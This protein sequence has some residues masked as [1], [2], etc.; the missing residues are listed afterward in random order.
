MAQGERA[1]GQRAESTAP[2]QDRPQ[3]AQPSSFSGFGSEQAAVVDLQG[4]A[5][6]FATTG[7]LTTDPPIPRVASD[8]ASRAPVVL[9]FDRACVGA[10]EPARLSPG[11]SGRSASVS[12]LARRLAQATQA[13]RRAALGPTSE[14]QLSDLRRTL[15]QDFER[16][17]LA[18]T[19][20]WLRANENVAKRESTRYGDPGAAQPERG[21]AAELR[22]AASNLAPLQRKVLDRLQVVGNSIAQRTGA[23]MGMPTAGRFDD[24]LEAVYGRVED[25]ELRMLVAEFNLTRRAYGRRFPV[26]LNRNTDFTELAEASPSELTMLIARTTYWVLLDIQQVRELLSSTPAKVWLL[27]PVVRATKLEMGIAPD[28]STPSGHVIDEHRAAIE[29]DERFL[30]LATGALSLLFGLAAIALTLGAATPAVAAG[31]AAILSGSSALLTGLTAGL[32]VVGAIGDYEKYELQHT[33]YGASLD[34]RTALASEDPSFAPVALAILGSVADVAAAIGA[35]R[36]LVQA[37]RLAREAHDLGILERIARAHARMLAEQGALKGTEDEFVEAVLASARTSVGGTAVNTVTH[38]GFAYRLRA[39][40]P[41]LSIREAVDETVRR[42][43]IQ[44]PED[45]LVKIEVGSR[46]KT[47]WARYLDLRTERRPEEIIT[48]NELF[49][50]VKPAKN[51]LSPMRWSTEPFDEPTEF[52]VIT[53]S[54]DTLGSDELFA[55]VLRHEMH[56]IEGLRRAFAGAGGQMTVGELRAWIRGLHEEAEALMPVVAEQVRAANAAAP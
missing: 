39:Q 17:A 6:N 20:K 14:E 50:E 9:A 26:L 16:R 19:E 35:T 1:R 33:A 15:L 24:N 12:P 44:I 25:R 5:G 28:A 10:A 27:E 54:P 34:P 8:V 2:V 32:G 21:D 40:G 7:L 55:A 30:A 37:A 4:T 22:A 41:W 42:G 49:Q 47:V 53:V 3:L 11:W 18:L 46:D 38:G 29:A 43:F 23:P 13:D 56:E 48:W 31:E 45:V 36:A 52:I 51:P